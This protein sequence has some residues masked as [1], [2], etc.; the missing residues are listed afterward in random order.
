MVDTVDEITRLKRAEIRGV[1]NMDG[2]LPELPQPASPSL[3]NPPDTSAKFTQLPPHLQTRP[4]QTYPEV[5]VNVETRT[6][7]GEKQKRPSP[8]IDQPQYTYF[9]PIKVEGKLPEQS[10]K[11]LYETGL[12]QVIQLP[13]GE[14]RIRSD[15]AVQIVG[16]Q[17]DTELSFSVR[18]KGE[19]FNKKGTRYEYYNISVMQQS[20]DEK[21]KSAAAEF[22]KRL[23]MSSRL[24]KIIQPRVKDDLPEL[25]SIFSL[26][27]NPPPEVANQTVQSKNA[28]PLNF[29]SNLFRRKK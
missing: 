15:D 29:F 2:F 14:M 3:E 10:G 19:G 16:M 8:D 25:P 20:S 18:I 4:L 26:M 27:D 13:N 21:E 5:A 12:F 1:L 6:I 28:S 23:K 22:L 11:V 7:G 24:T 17:R 9:A